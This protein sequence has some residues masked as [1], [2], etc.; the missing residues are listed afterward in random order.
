[1]GTA[2]TRVLIVDDSAVLRQVLSKE[3]SQHPG[4]H[5]VGTAPDPYVAR[6]MIVKQHPDVLSLDIQM[7]RM[8]GISFLRKLMHHHPMPVVIVSSLTR[9]GGDL[10]MEAMS[11]CAGRPL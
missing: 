4:I 10:A 8:D 5:V 1:M 7:P 6:D 9:Q 2:A 11:R 3:L